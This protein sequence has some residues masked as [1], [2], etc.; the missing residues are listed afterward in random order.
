MSCYSATGYYPC[1][2]CGQLVDP[3]ANRALCGSCHAATLAEGS[4]PL[5]KPAM[6]HI[7]IGFD[8]ATGGPLRYSVPLDD[9]VPMYDPRRSFR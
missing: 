1:G 9:D 2:S 3:L 5:A 4:S 8:C 6:L 7:H